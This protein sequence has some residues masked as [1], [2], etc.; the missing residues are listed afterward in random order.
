MLT[1]VSGG[2]TRS[3]VW[4]GPEHIVPWRPKAGIAKYEYTFIARQRHGKHIPAGM[5]TQ[6]T[7]E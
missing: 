5:N 4:A 7:I 2:Q 6:A 3:A 1:E